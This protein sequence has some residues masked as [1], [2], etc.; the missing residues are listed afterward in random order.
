M[1]D[2]HIWYP[3]EKVFIN[4]DWQK[5]NSG[6]YIEILNPSNGEAIAQIAQGDSKDVDDAVSAADRAIKG[7]WGQLTAV[8]RGRLLLKLSSLIKTR[9][10]DLAYI[11]SIDVGKPLSQSRNDAIALARY[12]E[13]YGGAADKITGVSI[14]YLNGYTVYTLREPYGVTGHIVP[15]NYPMQIIGRTLGAALAMGNACVLKPSEEACLTALAIGDLAIPVSYT[16]LR[17]H[18]T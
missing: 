9:L 8:D 14:P 17:A 13:F 1:L 3:T 11:E 18:E 15:W 6:K 4:G 16:H 10:D 2:E 7:P 12:F 5:P